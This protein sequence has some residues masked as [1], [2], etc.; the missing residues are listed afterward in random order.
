MTGPRARLEVRFPDFL[1]WSGSLFELGG[2]VLHDSVRDTDYFITARARIP[3][4]ATKQATKASHT[5]IRKRMTERIQRD[6]DIIVAR[7]HKGSSSPVNNVILT[8]D[9]S[10]VTLTHV[11]SQR[12]AGDGSVEA[13]YHSLAAASSSTSKIVLLYADSIFN[14]EGITLSANQRLLG[15]AAGHTINT[16]QYGLIDLPKASSG[17]TA[18]IIQNVT[19]RAVELANGSEVSGIDITGATTG[20]Y[21]SGIGGINL[22]RNNITNVEE[23]IVLDGLTPHVLTSNIHENIIDTVDYDGIYIYNADTTGSVSA[24]ITNNQL[25][26]LGLS[27]DYGAGIVFENDGQ[28]LI[29]TAS[30]NRIMGS[31]DEGILGLNLPTGTTFSAT[32]AR[33]QIEN[34]TFDG[35]AFENAG[36]TINLYLQDN[37]TDGDVPGGLA[38]YYISNLGTSFNLGATAGNPAIGSTDTDTDNGVIADEGNTRADQLSAPV[39]DALGPISIVDQ[40]TIPTP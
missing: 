6:P 26:N 16:D 1:G 2:E 38:D 20:I 18:P 30:D 22:N 32:V 35:I 9:G 19:G 13:P 40:A 37:Q 5:G 36:D 25:Q 7:Q 8:S 39:V 29:V 4:G 3:F 10:P 34:V 11:D 33:N 21:G 24:T 28:E 31:Y 27:L 14:G 23:G 15:E 17:T 12:T